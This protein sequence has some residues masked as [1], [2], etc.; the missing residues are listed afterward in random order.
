MLSS[1]PPAWGFGTEAR[2]K[3]SFAKYTTLKITY[4]LHYQSGDNFLTFDFFC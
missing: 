4:Y 2:S 1:A 3:F